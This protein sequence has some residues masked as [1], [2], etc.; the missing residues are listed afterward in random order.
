MVN[1]QRINKE[2]QEELAEKQ[3][4]GGE[5][6]EGELGGTMGRIWVRYVLVSVYTV[7]KNLPSSDC[8]PSPHRKK[9]QETGQTG[10]TG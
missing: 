4:R 3:K 1:V 7:F 8:R 2:R 5:E 6:E 9:K 10:Q